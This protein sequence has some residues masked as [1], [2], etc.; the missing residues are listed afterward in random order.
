MSDNPF[1]PPGTDLD[2]RPP[3]P[4]RPGS[5]ARAVAIGLA[6]DLGGS[7]LLNL[8][9][10]ILYAA[11]L[12]ASGLSH[13]DIKDALSHI[14]P[15]SWIAVTG[16]LLGAC[17][18]VLSGFVCARIVQRDEYRVGA[19]LATI[20]ALCTLLL[21]GGSDTGDDL[22]VLLTLCTA[23]CTMLGVKYGFE[24]NRRPDPAVE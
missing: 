19:V 4:T 20:S 12:Q 23:A 24:L 18:D 8:L 6:V 7:V 13:E 21:G 15:D 10:T 17:L 22:I 2:S 5:P 9:L 16:L 11:S 14:P 3:G 1:K